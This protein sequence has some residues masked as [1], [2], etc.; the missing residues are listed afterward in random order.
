MQAGVR[1]NVHTA[2][3][4]EVEKLGRENLPKLAGEIGQVTNLDIK[5]PQTRELR[6]GEKVTEIKGAPLDESG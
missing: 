6:S 4:H 2:T 5:I 1:T 3:G